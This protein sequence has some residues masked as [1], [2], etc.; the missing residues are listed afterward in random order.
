MK[1]KEKTLITNETPCLSNCSDSSKVTYCVISSSLTIDGEQVTTYGIG[2]VKDD[3]IIDTAPDIS[4]DFDKVKSLCILCN[5][6][7]LDP[8]HLHDVAQDAVAE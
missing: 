3:I 4:V 5:E 7:D 8:I 2:A 1:T 6:N